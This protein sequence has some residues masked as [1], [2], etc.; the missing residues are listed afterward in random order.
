MQF[1]LN[2]RKTL[3]NYLFPRILDGSLDFVS[4]I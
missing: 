2:E 1:K 4:D 3:E